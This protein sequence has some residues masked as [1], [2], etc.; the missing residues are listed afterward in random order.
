MLVHPALQ[1]SSLTAPFTQRRRSVRSSLQ[2]HVS[3]TPAGHCVVVVFSQ[4]VL[5]IIRYPT[6]ST[7]SEALLGEQSPT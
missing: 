4:V 3:L 1:R 5:G 7:N 2:V 6:W